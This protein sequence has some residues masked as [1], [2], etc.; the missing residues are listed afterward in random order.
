MPR[1]KWFLKELPLYQI[2]LFCQ[3][4]DGFIFL[5]NAVGG[6]WLMQQLEKKVVSGKVQTPSHPNSFTF[7]F[8]PNLSNSFTFTFSNPVIASLSHP[9]FPSLSLSQILTL[10]F[11]F[12]TKL[13]HFFFKYFKYFWCSIHWSLCHFPTLS[14][15]H[16]WNP[17]FNFHFLNFHTDPL[18][19]LLLLSAAPTQ[20]SLPFHFTHNTNALA[21][22]SISPFLILVLALVLHTWRWWAGWCRRRGCAP[23]RWRGRGGGAAGGR[24]RGAAAPWPGGGGAPSRGWRG[25]WAG[26][27]R[28][29]ESWLTCFSILGFSRF[30]FSHFHFHS[31]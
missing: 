17:H 6:W 16:F 13:F 7:T 28:G 19:E 29:G 21:L 26:G 31:Q 8:S 9:N 3:D 20:G 4:W 5:Q 10:T 23:S 11:T 1:W 15:S 27:E 2:K 18:I 30:Q 24:S 14:L 22:P 25:R 12:W